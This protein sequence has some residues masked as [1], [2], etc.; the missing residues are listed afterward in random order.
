VADKLGQPG[1]CCPECESWSLAQ[2]G[3]NDLGREEEMVEDP[4]PKEGLGGDQSHTG[5]ST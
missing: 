3:T 4:V 5:V 1:G 2:G